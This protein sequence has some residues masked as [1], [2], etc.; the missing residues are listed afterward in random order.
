M[1]DADLAEEE[2]EITGRIT[3]ASNATFL[4]RIGSVS[5]VYKP[6]AG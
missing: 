4:A 3:R 2:L 5:V 6:I 1:P